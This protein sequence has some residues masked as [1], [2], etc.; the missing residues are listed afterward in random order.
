MISKVAH[1]FIDF[2]DNVE[3]EALGIFL[4][5]S[6]SFFVSFSV[7]YSILFICFA[8]SYGWLIFPAI[9]VGC[10]VWALFFQPKK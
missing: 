1:K 9:F 3:P 7:V 2:C 5:L 8:Y 4:F 10:W 6:T